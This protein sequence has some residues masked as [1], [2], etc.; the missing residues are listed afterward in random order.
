M[1]TSRSLEQSLCRR[2]IAGD[3]RAWSELFH[4]YHPG[5]VEDVAAKLGS[6]RRDGQLVDELA[7]TVWENF[8]SRG[9]RAY[10]PARG[11]LRV[12][13]KVLAGREVQRRQGH[14]DPVQLRGL[15]SDFWVPCEREQPMDPILLTDLLSVLRPRL[16]RFCREELLGEPP[17]T[18]HRPYSPAYLKKMRH[19]V[20]IALR[21]YETGVAAPEGKNLPDQR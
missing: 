11:P 16:Q 15:P 5:L 17:Q 6:R 12:Y 2:A 19:E 4:R 21:A 1:S 7:S 14:A 20:R 18:T 3:Q 9:V 13:L 10:D 8:A